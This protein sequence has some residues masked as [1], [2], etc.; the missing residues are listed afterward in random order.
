M[1]SADN[2]FTALF[3]ENEYMWF[4][5]EVFSWMDFNEFISFVKVKISATAE[6]KRETKSQEK[7]A[8]SK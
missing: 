7:K 6:T 5:N 2:K 3:E 8:D 1:P 4:V